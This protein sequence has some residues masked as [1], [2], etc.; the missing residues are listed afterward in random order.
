MGGFDPRS[1]LDAM[2][3][4]Q[5]QGALDR[6][7]ASAGPMVAEGRLTTESGVP[8]STTDRIAQGTVYWTPL[9]FGTLK[10][11]NGNV[12]RQRRFGEVSKVLTGLLT[13]GKNYD[14]FM[15]DSDQSLQLSSAWTNDTT[16]ADALALQD[17]VAVLGSDHTL[18]HLGTMRATGTGTIED[19]GGY[20]GTT[21][22][23]A[24]R[25]L[26]NLFNPARRPLRV[27]DLTANWNYTTDVWRVA[28]GA[29]APL[30]CCEFVLCDARTSVEVRVLHNVNVNT[31]SARSAKAGVGLDAATPAAGSLIG[32]GYNAA[33]GIMIF[34]CSALYSGQPGL[35]YHSVRWL[36]KGAD[37][38]SG[39][40]GGT[41]TQ[42]G[43]IAVL[44]G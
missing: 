35:G 16:R 37:G 15:K 34:D 30:N 11:Y 10:T 33:A 25:F 4:G 12:W 31:N 13:S 43:L 1:L 18:V 26:S 29:T 2:T 8:V 27:I 19:S 20:T 7:F 22:V 38:G 23:G 39:F 5:V 41:A 6:M 32:Q 42:T 3:L 24:K 21:Q 14:L 17:G 44:E 36:E 9:G 28:N 40:N